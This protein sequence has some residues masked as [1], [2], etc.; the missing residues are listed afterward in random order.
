MLLG[1]R[2]LQLFGIYNLCYFFCDIIIIIIIIII[3][4]SG[5]HP[6]EWVCGRLHAGIVASN[7]AE[8]KDVSVLW[9]FCVVG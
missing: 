7:F 6:K 5:G 3:A 4:D 2:M 8:D 9:M 1:Y